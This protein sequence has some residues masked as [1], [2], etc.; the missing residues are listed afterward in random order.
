MKIDPLKDNLRHLYGDVAWFGVLAGTAMAYL[1]VYAARLGADAFQIAL[2]TAGPAGL[3][4]AFSLQ[5]GRWLE[6]RPFPAVTFRSSIAHRVIYLL[7]IILPWAMPPRLQVWGMV[8]L[9][10]V[11]A[12]PGTLLAI[13]FNATYAE[14]VPAEHR[15]HVTG[16][17]NAYLAIALTSSVLASGQVLN[18]VAFPLNFQI[19]FA[20]GALGAVMSSYHL[21]GLRSVMPTA[22]RADH[23]ARPIGSLLR[24]GSFRLPDAPRLSIG[25]RYLTRSGGKPM[26]RLDLL[27]GSFG[28]VLVTLLV[29]YAV[30]HLPIPLFPVFWVQELGLS[31]AAIGVGQ[32]GFYGTMF[33]SSLLAG[34]IRRR[35][36]RRQLILVS[37]MLYGIYPLLN[38]LARNEWL[39]WAASLAGGAVWGLL[40]VGL[41]DFLF[42]N[43]PDGDRP[44]H[45]A[46]HNLTMNA[47]ILIGSLMGPLASDVIGLRQSMLAA[48]VLRLA[49][50][51]LFVFMKG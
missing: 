18:R 8:G 10:L 26:V 41:I 2:L 40:N 51:G 16:R 9:V 30:Q 22:A 45:M 46:L 38:G 35:I 12:I 6:G 25:L 42:D 4:L 36:G 31:D 21:Y 5:S 29:F 28:G 3:N 43:V 33:L 50:A 17:R 39:V 14:I 44:A 7:F 34:P 32:A 20:V 27:R 48:A 37:A 1:S 23:P 15:A 19:V 24:P 47:G 49:V 11:G 13:A